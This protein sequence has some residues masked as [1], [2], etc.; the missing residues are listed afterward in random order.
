MNIIIAG[1]GKIGQTLI[2]K[3]SAEGHALTLIDLR[4]Q[5]LES[6]VERYDII[7]SAGNCA[8]KEVLL[9]SGVQDADLLIAAT[10]ADE[11]NLLCCMT[12]H[13]INKNLH[14]IARIRDP[15]YADQVMTKRDVFPLS[16][17]INPEK[18]A[19]IEIERL[20]KYPGFLR[21]DTFAKGR[22]VIVELRIDQKSALCN[23]SLMNL[24]NVV[25]CRVL[26]CAV[27]RAGNAIAPSGNFVLQEG[28]RIFVTASTGNLT[29]L[30]KNLGIITRKVRDVMLC[31]GGRISYY[32]ASLLEKDKISV[33]ILERN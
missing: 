13:G 11:V 28:D 2:R 7:A 29:T 23:V 8:S 10:S 19:A 32:L 4:Q 1:G 21:R 27:L 20:L 18:L 30:L 33:Q 5:V 3:L 25:K 6:T 15:E 9:R 16:M 26:V 24:S 31:G 12:A 22:S 17:T 14:T